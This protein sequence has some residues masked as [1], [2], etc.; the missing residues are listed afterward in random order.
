MLICAPT[1]THAEL[2]ETF[3]RAGKHVFSE[4]PVDLDIARAAD[5]VAIASRPAARSA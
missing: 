2:I 3:A 4:K 5:V 1:D